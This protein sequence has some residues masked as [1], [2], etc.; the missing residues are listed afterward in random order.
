MRVVQDM[1][2]DSKTLV[3][4]AVGDTDGL[5]VEVGLHQP[6]HVSTGDGQDDRDRCNRE[7]AR[8]RIL[9]V[10]E[11]IRELGINHSKQHAAHQ[12]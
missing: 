1:Y 8:S 11:L 10:D 3:R 2:K 6:L 4:C 12:R 7:A 9:K 5:K